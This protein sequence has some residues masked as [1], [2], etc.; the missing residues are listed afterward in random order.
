MNFLRRLRSIKE[1]KLDSQRPIER[2]KLDSQRSIEQ[3]KLDSQR[4]IEQ[5]NL[6]SPQNKYHPSRVT[7]DSSESC[8]LLQ[9]DSAVLRALRTPPR[10][11]RRLSVSELIMKSET[12]NSSAALFPLIDKVKYTSKLSGENLL[13]NDA[14]EEHDELDISR[15]FVND[16]VEQDDLKKSNLKKSNPKSQKEDSQDVKVFENT[17]LLGELTLATVDNLTPR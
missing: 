17:K 13:E 11:S 14:P 16:A 1:D 6:D 12:L 4:S 9:E 8:R 7:D 2:D 15:Y 3:G 10:I 5:D